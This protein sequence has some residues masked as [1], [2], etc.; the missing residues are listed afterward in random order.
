MKSHKE[1]KK[2]NVVIG[3]H[4]FAVL[5]AIFEK[6]WK[7]QKQCIRSLF[8]LNRNHFGF[9]WSASALAAHAAYE[10]MKWMMVFFII[11]YKFT[12]PNVHN[13]KPLIQATRA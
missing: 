1:L 3:F 9:N 6:A 12:L 13:V 7:K 4:H 10:E 8:F 5:C 11:T 2:L